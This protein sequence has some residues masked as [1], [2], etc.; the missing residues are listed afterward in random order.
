MAISRAAGVNEFS[1]RLVALVLVNHN[2]ALEISLGVFPRYV[3]VA[4]R[5]Q[6]NAFPSS[7]LD[8]CLVGCMKIKRRK[9]LSTLLTTLA[10]I[11]QIYHICLSCFLFDVKSYV[12]I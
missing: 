6:F 11:P 9:I 2:S 10:I 4:A 1:R 8:R 5:A 7:Q 3:I 12:S